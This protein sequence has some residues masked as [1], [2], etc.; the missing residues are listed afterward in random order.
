MLGIVADAA[1]VCLTDQTTIRTISSPLSR[2]SVSTFAHSSARWNTQVRT[3]WRTWNKG[4]HVDI[5]PT[6]GY[7]HI[8]VAQ[9]QC[10]YVRCIDWPIKGHVLR[11]EL[12][13]VCVCV[14]VDGTSLSF[15]RASWPARDMEAGSVR[16]HA[17]CVKEERREVW[18]PLFT[19][20]KMRRQ[21]HNALINMFFGVGRPRLLRRGSHFFRS[22]PWCRFQQEK[23]QNEGRAKIG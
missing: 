10:A 11:A 22:E 18:W 15:L 17:L 4:M 21:H 13:N 2:I 6:H 8:F 9:W 5:L 1:D 16:A 14:F 23:T 3:R 19:H 7:R 12:G 20:K